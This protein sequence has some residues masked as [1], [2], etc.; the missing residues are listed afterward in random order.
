[1][2]L[3]KFL[4]WFQ[5]A[6]QRLHSRMYSSAMAGEGAAVEALSKCPR[7]ASRST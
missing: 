6:P 5:Q 4:A 3:N 7:M 1:M 2:A